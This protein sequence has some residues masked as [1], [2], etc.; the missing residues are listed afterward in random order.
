ML[1]VMLEIDTM[2]LPRKC[3]FPRATVIKGML[4]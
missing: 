4:S 2:H 1:T 3:E